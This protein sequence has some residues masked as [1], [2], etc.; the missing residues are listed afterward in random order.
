MIE[1]LIDGEALELN[2]D[3]DAAI[4]YAVADITD[5]N[6][7]SSG[8]SKTIEVPFTPNNTRVMQFTN[9]IFSREQFNNELHTAEIVVD[10]QSVMSGTAVVEKYG[11]RHFSRTHARNGYFNI[12]IVGASYEWM[13][14]LDKPINE[15]SSNEAV[16][17]ALDD[18]YA[19]SVQEEATLVKFIPIDKGAFYEKNS[20]DEYEDRDYLE[21]M[22][23]HPFLNVWKTLQ[24]IL[25]AL[26]NPQ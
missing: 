17:Y 8:Y 24:L 3:T 2:Q 18:V 15:L 25:R 6:S 19:N 4:S 23:Y 1:L 11:L 10:S 5:P 16:T 14:N 26:K 9:E 13:V 12:S 22:D 21:L 20:D 7:S